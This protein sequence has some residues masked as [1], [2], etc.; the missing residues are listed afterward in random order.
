MPVV[1]QQSAK[2]ELGQSPSVLDL[3][4]LSRLPVLVFDMTSGSVFL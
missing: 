3:M 2:I 4:V 1:L